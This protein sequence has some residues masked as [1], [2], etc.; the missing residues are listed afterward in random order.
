MD[1]N[2][3]SRYFLQ[4]KDSK[5]TF[6]STR[7]SYDRLHA[8]TALELFNKTQYP[9][10]ARCRRKRAWIKPISQYTQCQKHKAELTGACDEC[11]DPFCCG[12]CCEECS[13]FKICR[14]AVEKGD[15]LYK[16]KVVVGLEIEYFLPLEVFL[17]KPR[18]KFMTLKFKEQRQHEHFIKKEQDETRAGETE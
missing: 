2:K 10:Q 18:H 9:L 17:R 15:E 6:F 12:P 8:Y 13:K 1:E 16:R 5:P 14:H 7:N 4:L 3:V 11:D